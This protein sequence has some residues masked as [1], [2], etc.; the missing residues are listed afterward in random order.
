MDYIV[1]CRKCGTK[2]PVDSLQSWGRRRFCD[3]CR[4]AR[5]KGGAAQA[6][7]YKENADV[8]RAKRRARYKLTGR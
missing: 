8:L 3:L 4:E 1:K 5:L 7:Y 2:F 6:Q